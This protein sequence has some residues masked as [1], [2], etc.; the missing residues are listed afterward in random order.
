MFFLIYVTFIAIYGMVVRGALHVHTMTHINALR[1]DLLAM[2][3]IT[4]LTTALYA[5]WYVGN[6]FRY[7][8]T[9]KKRRIDVMVRKGGRYMGGH[10]IVRSR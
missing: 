5:W 10:T 9:M 4:L 1:V 2:V 7:M 8:D 3:I 6:E